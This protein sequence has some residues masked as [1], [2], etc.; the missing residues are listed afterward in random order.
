MRIAC[1]HDSDHLLRSYSAFSVVQARASAAD[2]QFAVFFR[3]LVRHHNL[4]PERQPVFE[5]RAEFPVGANNRSVWFQLVP[6]SR[7]RLQ[8][9]ASS[10]SDLYV[11]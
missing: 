5:S 8:A 11:C 1:E 3:R 9:F 4:G 7:C 6:A 2:L 10:S